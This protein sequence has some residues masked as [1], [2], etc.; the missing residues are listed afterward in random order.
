MNILALDLGTKTGFAFDSGDAFQCG[1]WTLGQ[2]KEIK[3]WG[4][5]RLTRRKDPRIKRLCSH[6][7]E[8]RT[9]DVIVFED[10][11]FSLYTQQ[12]QL[13]SSLR[14]CIWL[15]GKAMVTECVP[16]ATLKKFATGNG[17][18]TKESME[19]SL[20]KNHLSLWRSG[21]G[22]DTVDATWLWLWAKKNFSR[23]KA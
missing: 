7:A 12:T 5:E 16:V 9:F 20:K 22:D 8:L 6:L 18:A 19:I 23:A 1:T 17:A 14:S 21:I 2:P 15:C 10:V 3:Q 4:I 11:Q 13:W